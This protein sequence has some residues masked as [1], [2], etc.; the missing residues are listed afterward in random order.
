MRKLYKNKLRLPHAL[1][2]KK[3]GRSQKMD[4][5]YS[6]LAKDSSSYASSYEV[7]V[8]VHDASSYDLLGTLF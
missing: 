7:Q 4:S 6:W 5:V 1:I 8:Q 2:E 3:K